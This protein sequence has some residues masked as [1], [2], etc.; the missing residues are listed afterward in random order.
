MVV[1]GLPQFVIHTGTAYPLHSFQRVPEQI[2]WLFCCLFNI[3][4]LLPPLCSSPLCAVCS[5]PL[6]NKHYLEV[7]DG[8]LKWG[9]HFFLSQ[10]WQSLN[11]VLYSVV[12]LCKIL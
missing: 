6:S 7:E 4:S 12:S 10:L 8:S 1:P 2:P 5:F 3:P 9:L 11:A